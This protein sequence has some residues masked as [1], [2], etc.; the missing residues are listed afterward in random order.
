VAAL[1]A[2]RAAETLA[3]ERREAEW[4]ST[5]LETLRAQAAVVL[6]HVS[7]DIGMWSEAAGVPIDVRAATASSLEMA[8]YDLKRTAMIAITLVADVGAMKVV[9]RS[10][11]RGTTR[12][13]ELIG[14]HA[15]EP[16]VLARALVEEFLVLAEPLV[17]LEEAT[18]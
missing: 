6:E 7:R 13:I 16:A 15:V 1:R 18:R 17:Q 2:A 11:S 10:D 3:R 5:P 14:E 4:A 12:T 8:T 9:I